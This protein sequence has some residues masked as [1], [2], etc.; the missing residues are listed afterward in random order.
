[1]TNDISSFTDWIKIK[2]K[3]SGL[4]LTCKR[5]IKTGDFGYWSKSS[6]AIIHEACY[7]LQNSN[8][9]EIESH[10]QEKCGNLRMTD[11]Y[12]NGN[13]FRTDVKTGQCFICNTLVDTQDPLIINLIN[14]EEKTD[15]V[16]TMYCSICMNGF[17]SR[18]LREY[19]D[20]FQRKIKK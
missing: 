5:K 1:M 16:E 15:K 6:K 19:K 20:A 18:V 4:C 14:V 12:N 17:N 7:S 2:I 9:Y 10:G 3:F 8:N 11:K 13:K